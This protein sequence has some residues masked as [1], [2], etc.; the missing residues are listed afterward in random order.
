MSTNPMSEFLKVQGKPPV[1]STK[2]MT[3]RETYLYNMGFAT[4]QCLLRRRSQ[5]YALRWVVA[6]SIVGNVVQA[7]ASWL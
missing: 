7:I 1:T 6:V 4:Y 2:D 5:V 3:E